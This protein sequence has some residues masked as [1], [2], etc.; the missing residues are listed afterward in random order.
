MTDPNHSLQDEFDRHF[1]GDGPPPDTDDPEAAAYHVVFS[2]LQEEPEGDLPDDFAAQVA[3]RVAVGREPALAWTD[4]LL[5]FLAVAGL[6]TAAVLMP[7]SLAPLWESLTLIPDAIQTMSTFVRLDVL[8]AVG[9]VLTLTLGL[10]ALL[11]RWTPLRR[12]PTPS[13]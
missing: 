4:V 11:A 6:S 1:R 5:L 7:S 2:A 8:V 12:A 9:L 10:D 3:D 13:S